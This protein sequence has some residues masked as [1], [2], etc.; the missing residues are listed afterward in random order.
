MKTNGMKMVKGHD[1]NNFL[2]I[3][4]MALVLLFCEYVFFHNI[5]GND[6]LFGDRGDGRL[7]TLLNEHW[8]RFF[9]GKEGFSEIAMFWPVKDAFGYTDLFLGYGIV[10]SVFR[11]FGVNMFF[12]YKYTLIL[13]H[14]FAAFCMYYLLKC[15]I[16]ISALWALFGTMAFCFSDTFSHHLLHT[17]LESLSF[18]PALLILFI[19][20]LNNYSIRMKRNIYAVGF[21]VLFVLLTYTSWYVACFTGIFGL[22]FIFVY[23]IRL[24]LDKIKPLHCFIEYVNP[25]WKDIVGYV[26][27][28]IILYIPFIMIYVPVLRSSNGYPY[29]GC[30]QYMPEFIDLINVRENSL[31]A[32]WLIRMLKLDSRGYTME[33]EVGFSMILLF[34]FIIGTVCFFRIKQQKREKRIGSLDILS[35][36]V[37]PSVI[38]TIYVCIFSIIRLSSNGV[39]FWILFY[40]LIP[41]ARSVRAIGRFFIWL[42][43]PVSVVSSYMV[44]KTI[45][46]KDGYRLPIA[47]CA[48]VLMFVSNINLSGVSSAWNEHGESSFIKGVSVPPDEAEVFFI[49]DSSDTK[50]EPYI[51]QL[52]AYEIATV[53]DIKTING[54]SGQF[55]DEW[56]GIWDPSAEIYEKSVEN[57][58]KAK[59]LEHVYAYDR[60]TNT[61]SVQF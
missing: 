3:L 43:F 57:W 14:V 33:N 27:L 44:D 56:D 47:L 24:R 10:F 19:G 59:G 29:S 17:Q 41:V 5:I 54:Y 4:V 61:W 13:L 51:Y 7:T 16:K 42:S 9:N 49:K 12:A 8:W 36:E 53:Y 45:K 30:A 39:S 35:F 48:V 2:G 38:I 34:V 25:I 20:F 26:V 40:Y 50:D 37:L 22:V 18:L 11:M 55:P 32:G 28:L 31:M 52:D 21:I 58:A 46:I 1:K 60:E 15:K 23:Y 6:S